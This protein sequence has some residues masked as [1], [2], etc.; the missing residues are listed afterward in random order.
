LLNSFFTGLNQLLVVYKTIDHSKS[1]WKNFVYVHVY[2]YS[3]YDQ[4]QWA[5]PN[6]VWNIS[7]CIIGWAATIN[8]LAFIIWGLICIF[9]PSH[10]L[11]LGAKVTP[12]TVIVAYLLS[13]WYSSIFNDEEYPWFSLQLK[14]LWLNIF[15]PFSSVVNEST[16][17]RGKFC[18][19]GVFPE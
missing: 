4:W 3:I 11:I 13:T 17:F 1:N 5:P 9:E 12:V 6:F 8:E 14:D 19:G 15:P 7:N 18:W 16:G 10:I 2:L